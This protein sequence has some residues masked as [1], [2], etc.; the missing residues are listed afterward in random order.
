MRKVP[1]WQYQNNVEEKMCTEMVEKS[2][3]S[4]FSCSNGATFNFCP[5]GD[6][7]INVTPNVTGF[8]VKESESATSVDQ[9]L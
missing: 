8:A 2:L 6:V 5:S 9:T 7:V 4:L 1:A 3:S